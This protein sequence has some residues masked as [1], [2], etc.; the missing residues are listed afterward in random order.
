MQQVLVKKCADSLRAQIKDKYN[1]SLKAAHAHELV[2]AFFGY[3]S[4]N[5][6]LADTNYP[7]DNLCISPI[8]VMM[9]NSYVDQRRKDLH[10]LPPQLPDSYTLG[11]AVYVALFDEEYWTSQY[12]PFRSFPKMTEYL[13][14]NSETFNHCFK[15][16]SDIKMRHIIKISEADHC[17]EISVLHTH[18]I[19][20]GETQAVGQTMISLRRIAGKIGFSEPQVSV[21]QWTGGAKKIIR[22]T[23]SDEYI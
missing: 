16:Y 22:P 20:T 23:T 6:L 4:K 21:E 19:H 13:L 12:P 5:S 14:K 17:V 1:I 11:E 18:L 10:D 7:L 8:V 3:K 9:P 2:A 15:F